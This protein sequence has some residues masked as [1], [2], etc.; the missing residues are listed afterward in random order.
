VQSGSVRLISNDV[1]QPQH[2]LDMSL[3]PC[4]SGERGLLGVAIDPDFVNNGYVYLYFTHPSA[5]LGGCVN[6]ASRFTMSGDA[7]DPN[8][9]VILVDN[10]ASQNGNHNGGDL[11][12]GGDGYLYISVGDSGTDPRGRPGINMAAQDLSLL[13]GKILRVVPSTGDPA[14]GNPISGRG[15]RAVACAA[16]PRQRRRRGAKSSTPGACATRSGS[17]STPTPGPTGSSSTTSGR[18]RARKWTKAAS[19]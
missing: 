9:E 12:I 16:T 19:A 5:A 1:L 6:R 11:E 18:A 8:S 3:A 2:A 17:P 7:I 15:R 14:P 13:Q 10:I 4:N